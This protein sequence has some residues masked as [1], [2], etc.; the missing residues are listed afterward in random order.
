MGAAMTVYRWSTTA[1]TS[2][3]ADATINWA[4]GQAPSSENDSAR[5]MMAAIAKWRNDLSG[6]L[7]TAGTSTS[8]TLTSNQVFSSLSAMDGATL[9]FKVNATCGANPTL[10]VDSLGAKNLTNPAGTQISAGT[11]TLNRIYQATY[12]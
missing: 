7:T 12:S 6:T 4:E 1:A 3:T 11:L 8:Y 5:A 10:N 9:L 2:S